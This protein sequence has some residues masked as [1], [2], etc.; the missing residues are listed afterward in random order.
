MIKL[1]QLFFKYVYNDDLENAS[2]ISL[3]H[4]IPSLSFKFLTIV[5]IFCCFFTFLIYFTVCTFT[6]ICREYDCRAILS[7]DIFSYCTVE[8]MTFSL[9]HIFP[10]PCFFCSFQERLLY[11]VCTLWFHSVS[12]VAADLLEAVASS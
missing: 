10:N 11:R 1:L 9:P 8:G 3:I 5:S 6:L 7:S 2:S 4:C 12:Y